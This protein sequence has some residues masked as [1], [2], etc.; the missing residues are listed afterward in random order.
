M[1]SDHDPCVAY[2]SKAS[3]DAGATPQGVYEDQIRAVCGPAAVEPMLRAFREVEA[4]TTALEDHGMGL[5]FPAPNMMMQHWS[6]SSFPK[7]LGEDRER[8]RRALAAVRSVPEPAGL[9]AKTYLR[10]WNGRLQFGVSYLDAI[11]ALNKGAT[12]ESLARGALKKGDRRVFKE[13]L[14]GALQQAKMAQATAFQ[15]IDTFAGVAKNQADRGAIA[16]MAE[17]VDRPLKRKVKELHAEYDKVRK[18]E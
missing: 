9:D 5:S 3:W 16:T 7:E 14:V 13:K 2:L 11:E 8:F 4:V 1:I 17:Y 18:T 15:A 12:A 6:P 10:Y